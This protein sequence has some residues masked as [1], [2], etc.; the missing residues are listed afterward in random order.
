MIL[1]YENWRFF[2]GEFAENSPSFPKCFSKF[3]TALDI[4]VV[5]FILLV[6]GRR[7]ENR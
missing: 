3:A 4:S 1:L 7:I 2:T 5:K 6:G